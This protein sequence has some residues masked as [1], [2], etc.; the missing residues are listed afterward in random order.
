MNKKV[1]FGILYSVAALIAI[2]GV[3][4]SIYGFL[5]NATFKIMGSNFPGA[6]FG[7][8]AA[9]LGV[10]YTLSLN[11]LKKKIDASNASFSWSNFK[12]SRSV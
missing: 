2:S 8:V 5:A 10:R 6:I 9:F 1:L 4:F 11:K 7:L 12:R 3:L